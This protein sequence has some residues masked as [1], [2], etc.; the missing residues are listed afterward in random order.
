MET[1]QSDGSDGGGGGAQT[2]RRSRARLIG[3]GAAAA[4]G[5]AATAALWYRFAHGEDGYVSWSRR[6]AADAPDAVVVPTLS[7]SPDTDD[8]APP[9]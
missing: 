8:I 7:R 2:N 9:F 4:L 3:L 6:E 1:R 5:L